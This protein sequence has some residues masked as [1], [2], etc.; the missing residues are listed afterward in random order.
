MN[1]LKH[2]AGYEKKLLLIAPGIIQPIQHLKVEHLGNHNPR[3]H[4]DELLIALSI[5]AVTNPMAGYAIDQLE[6]LRGCEAHSS[7]ILSHVDADLFKKIGV[8]LSCEPK[9]QAKK[10]YHK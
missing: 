4:T 2:L 9:Y 6:K 1:A 8:N 10:L 3:L 7:V 5:C